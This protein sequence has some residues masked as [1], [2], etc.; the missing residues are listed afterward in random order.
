MRQTGGLVEA[1]H[2]MGCWAL[3]LCSGLLLAMAMKHAGNEQNVLHNIIKISLP[4]LQPPL[5]CTFIPSQMSR[6]MSVRIY[7]CVDSSLGQVVVLS[8]C[9][10]K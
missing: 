9:Q 6:Y 2:G 5:K 3:A 7:N 4:V 10:E 8:L 1:A